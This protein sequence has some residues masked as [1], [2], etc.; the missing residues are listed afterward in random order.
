MRKLRDSSWLVKF[1]LIST[2]RLLQRRI[3]SLHMFFWTEKKEVSKSI[4]KFIYHENR[5]ASLKADLWP[6]I[7]R[8]NL[9]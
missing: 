4:I 2:L 1:H 3:F 6:S 7:G 8:E 9:L 5:F